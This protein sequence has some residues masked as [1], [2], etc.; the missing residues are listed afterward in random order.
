MLAS[1]AALFVSSGS[2]EMLVFHTL[3][4]GNMGQFGAPGTT[5]DVTGAVTRGAGPA[6]ARGGVA[7]GSAA[8]PAPSG[9]LRCALVV[10]AAP[11][12]ATKAAAAAIATTRRPA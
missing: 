8:S 5:V 4:A 9:T 3:F 2:L 7:L 10:D 1:H 12:P 6:L 11:Q